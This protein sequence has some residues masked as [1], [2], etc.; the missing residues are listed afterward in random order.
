MFCAVI[1]G[2]VPAETQSISLSARRARS[3]RL[4]DVSSAEPIII[5][6]I[7][8]LNPGISVAGR[9]L[10]ELA[11]AYLGL[12]DQACFSAVG[13]GRPLL[14]RADMAGD[15]IRF[16]QSNAGIL[17]EDAIVGILRDLPRIYGK[18]LE[19]RSYSDR[20]IKS[21][22]IN[23]GLSHN[24]RIIE[25]TALAFEAFR[26]AP[27]GY[28]IDFAGIH[29]LPQGQGSIQLYPEQVIATY[30]AV[31][32]EVF[33]DMKTGEGKTLVQGAVAIAGVKALGLRM[34]LLEPNDTLLSQNKS[35]L[36]NVFDFLGFKVAVSD[37]H[38]SSD[39]RDYDVIWAEPS[40]M[41]FDLL[42]AL[43]R[44]DSRILTPDF[45]G[46]FN[47]LGI[48]ADECDQVLFELA[49]HPCI[50]GSPDAKAA[51][52]F[53]AEMYRGTV[54]AIQGLL[55][56]GKNL[57]DIS[58]GDVLGNEYFKSASGNY[59]AEMK[60]MGFD[61]T[62]IKKN[63]ASFAQIGL[64]AFNKQE[65]RD[66]EIDAE[67]GNKIVLIG[68]LT[69]A[70]LY[71]MR[72]MAGLDQMLRAR[73]GHAFIPAQGETVAQITL[74]SILKR[75][76]F[77]T[78]GSGSQSLWVAETKYLYDH[79]TGV[80]P[81]RLPLIRVDEARI[82]S[83]QAD[84]I[85]GI[86][87]VISENIIE[88]RAAGRTPDPIV[89][90]ASD[91]VRLEEIVGALELELGRLGI[92]DQEIIKFTPQELLAQDVDVLEIIRSMGIPG[93][94][95]HGTRLLGRGVDVK[96]LGGFQLRVL[97]C[98]WQA[99]H[100]LIQETGRAGRNG[101]P[102]HTYWFVSLDEPVFGGMDTAL[103]QA[104]GQLITASGD[105]YLKVDNFLTEKFTDADFNS[106]PDSIQGFA[107]FILGSWGQQRA[108]VLSEN[109]RF[110][111]QYAPTDGLFF[112]F[113]E[114]T[115]Q[116]VNS[117]IR[118]LESLDDLRPAIDS[119]LQ[120]QGITLDPSFSFAGLL[121]G[122]LLRYAQPAAIALARLNS[123]Y[124]HILNPHISD[125]PAY[126]NYERALA[127]A[128]YALFKAVVLDGS[129]DIGARIER[130]IELCKIN[131]GMHILRSMYGGP[132]TDSRFM[133]LSDSAAAGISIAQPRGNPIL[134]HLA[135]TP[136]IPNQS[137]APESVLGVQLPS[138]MPIG[139][140]YIPSIV[141]LHVGF[142][143]IDPALGAGISL[144]G[145]LPVIF[146]QLSLPGPWLLALPPGP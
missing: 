11:D 62:T 97:V 22:Q 96:V 34:F 120:A 123:I 71:G 10:S 36:N 50:I 116:I 107:R 5:K 15:V 48:Y 19:F 136:A 56:Q 24:D 4:G 60:E 112:R 64:V 82:S 145:I 37:G 84:K 21:Y 2:P 119:Q 100:D 86:A 118:F 90:I 46:V 121:G 140:I 59:I 29:L 12:W 122:E 128:D 127:Q 79:G 74:G 25:G 104:L 87:S 139:M 138:G 42:N 53:V 20:D 61:D 38:F 88:A 67:N 9:T 94:E 69:G 133:P 78:G 105:G 65:G 49:K 111:G 3:F 143:M 27:T 98:D 77:S 115:I 28:L 109:V 32:H 66:F 114:T 134:Q 33:L 52:P 70:P 91:R 40:K 125:D 129:G 45:M 93:A 73:F 99:H 75:V 58:L 83:S 130:F 16:I 135:S 124:R 92:R 43:F 44:G 7:Q 101:M 81:R 117:D 89:L 13:D 85:R 80:V 55:A 108:E 35:A 14:Q 95:T 41:A 76:D 18:I 30:L 39:W 54:Q 8:Q 63:I 57:K 26:R 146:S 68:S 110:Q 1:S 132:D 144:T 137:S 141:G 126:D 51:E 106:W 103:H 113:L 142:D 31:A 23:P 131:I 102:G 47:Q 72:Y 17:N 6:V